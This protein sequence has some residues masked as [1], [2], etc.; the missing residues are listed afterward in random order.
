MNDELD[1]LAEKKII[2]KATE[3]LIDFKDLD[4]LEAI[5]RE[6]MQF[7]AW[8]RSNPE[9]TRQLEAVLHRLEAV[10]AE[11]HE[12][13]TEF[14]RALGRWNQQQIEQQVKASGPA[15]KIVPDK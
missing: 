9:R 2:V 4:L 6:Q 10:E 14:A 7:P 5:A 15:L 3:C 8:K 12:R 1:R 13:C 11:R